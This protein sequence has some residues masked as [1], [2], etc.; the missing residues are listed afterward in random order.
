MSSGITRLNQPK[1]RQRDIEEAVGLPVSR[2]NKP[3]APFIYAHYPQ[4]WSWE[5]RTDE[6]GKRYGWLPRLKKITAT[7]AANGVSDPGRGREVSI[8]HM[9]KTL[10]GA[11]SKGGRII[12][13]SDERLADYQGY[14]TYYDTDTGGKW[15]VE[16]GQEATV[17][18][19][20]QILWN[21][22]DV[23]PAVLDFRRHIRDAGLG[24]PLMRE[25]FLAKMA[26]ERQK[27]SRAVEMAGRNPGLQHR[28][29]AQEEKIKHMEAD[30]LEY[31]KALAGEQESKPKRRAPIK[32]SGGHKE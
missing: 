6:N 11:V 12:Y 27:L 24:Y 8:S 2:V 3:A 9:R 5:G 7:P 4:S 19:T 18:P 21:S 29:E 16:P 26:T 15:F 28:V 13:P 25:F 14:D 20:G 23:I 10:D 22:D 1:K 30:Y 32:R 17:L 31:G